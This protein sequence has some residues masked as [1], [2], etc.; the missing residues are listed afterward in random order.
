VALY[1]PLCPCSSDMVLYIVLF[2]IFLNRKI[3]DL[4]WFD[5]N[6]T[7]RTCKVLGRTLNRLRNVRAGTYQWGFVETGNTYEQLYVCVYSEG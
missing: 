1:S 4:I 6:I 7:E 5:L 3:F 2:C